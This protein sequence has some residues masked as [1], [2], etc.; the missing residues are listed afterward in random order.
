ML[1]PWT[2]RYEG[3][4][5]GEGRG[6]RGSRVCDSCDCG[7]GLWSWVTVTVTARDMVR[8]MVGDVVRVRMVTRMKREAGSRGRKGAGEEHVVGGG[9]RVPCCGGAGPCDG[10]ARGQLFS[11]LG[12]ASDA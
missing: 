12:V 11:N 1:V 7:C 5:E 10:E 6:G 3:G 9:R 2:F 4:H 8:D